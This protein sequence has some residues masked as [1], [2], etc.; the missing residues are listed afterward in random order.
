M[1]DFDLS[2][3]PRFKALTHFKPEAES[4]IPLLGPPLE[5]FSPAEFLERVNSLYQPPNTTKRYKPPSLKGKIQKAP[6]KKAPGVYEIRFQGPEGELKLRFGFDKSKNC[7]Y[8]WLLREAPKRLLCSEDQLNNFLTVKGF[9]L[10][11]SC[12]G[13]ADLIIES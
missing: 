10:E 7:P 6:T 11:K 12:A 1:T 2:S 3:D 4:A 8:S 13:E 5:S 9:H